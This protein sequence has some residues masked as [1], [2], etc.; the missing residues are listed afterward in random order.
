MLTSFLQSEFFLGA[1]KYVVESMNWPIRLIALAR[2]PNM[3]SS[4][5]Y[6]SWKNFSSKF[7]LTACIQTLQQRENFTPCRNFY[8]LDSREEFIISTSFIEN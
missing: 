3:A 4:G 1:V 2:Q 6:D 5:N 7:Y 8:F